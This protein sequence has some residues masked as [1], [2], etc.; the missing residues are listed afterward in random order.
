MGTVILC[1]FDLRPLTKKVSGFQMSV[2]IF[3][4]RESSETESPVALK[5]SLS[6]FH[7][8]RK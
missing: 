2:R 5:E 3:Q 1:S 4:S 6:S 8:W 7:V